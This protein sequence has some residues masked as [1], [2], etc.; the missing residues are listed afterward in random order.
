MNSK[1]TA[2][3]RSLALNLATRHSA[4]RLAYWN[5]LL[6]ALG[7]GLVSAT[8]VIYL[9][10]DFGVGKRIG[11]SIGLILASQHFI[12]V[13]RIGTPALL[14]RLGDRRLFC[15]I[16]FAL[17]GLFLLTLPVIAAPDFLPS[18]EASLAAL[19]ALWGMHHLMQYLGT[20]AFYSWLADLVPL[21]IRG[22]FFGKRERW[23]VVGQAVAAIAAGLFAEWWNRHH[24]KPQQWIG[25]ALLAGLG[26]IF[27][28]ASAIPIWFMPGGEKSRKKAERYSWE[29]LL[30]PF[31][32]RGFFGF[33][34]FGFWFSFSNGL[35]QTLQYTYPKYV[36]QIVLFLMLASQTA[37][38]LGQIGV[39]PYLGKAVDR[40]GNKSIML[41]CLSITAQGPLFYF[42]ST[43]DSWWWFLGSSVAWIAY[44]G[45]NIGIPN[46]MLKIAPRG[47]N[48]NYLTI[49][50]TC[51][52]L[53]YGMNTLLGGWLSDHFGKS[54]WI[55]HGF[56]WDFNQTMFFLGWIARCLGIV[57]LFWVIEPKFSRSR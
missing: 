53:C 40:F 41:I 42:F 47:E 38:R 37:M 31:Q 52:G 32:D 2:A 57:F 24:P 20:I 10:M 7:N 48:A 55:W 19:V 27:I 51:T 17:S 8:L 14:D 21:A 9:A 34:L 5:G 26:A 35:T 49:Y 4:R 13:L 12:G 45:L 28:L 15:S 22:R 36:L 23:M 16:T 1:P 50:F 33:L 6:W 54:Y 11:L 46:L 18:P 25:Y 29:K 56:S 43:P 39:C 44:A 30:E 3:N